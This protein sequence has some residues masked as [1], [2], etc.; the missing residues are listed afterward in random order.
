[1]PNK[2]STK[3]IKR[4]NTNESKHRQKI[5]TY[6][7]PKEKAF[8]LNPVN[9]AAAT[10]YQHPP[11]LSTLLSVYNR[12]TTPQKLLLVLVVLSGIVSVATAVKHTSP[13]IIPG[14]RR[15]CI[16]VKKSTNLA[17]RC[18]IEGKSDHAYFFKKHGQIGVGYIPLSDQ[19]FFDAYTA[20]YNYR[21]VKDV[22][23]VR[24]AQIRLFS[25]A[26]K[27]Y[28]ASRLIPD[29]TLSE[30]FLR[31]GITAEEQNAERSRYTQEIKTKY[32]DKAIVQYAVAMTLIEDMHHANIGF[33]KDG[34][35]IVDS[36]FMPVSIRVY[37]EIAA[38]LNHQIFPF[39]LTLNNVQSMKE[40]YEAMLD[41]K[42]PIGE[43]GLTISEENFKTVLN[44]YIY[45]CRFI[46]ERMATTLDKDELNPAIV[47]VWAGAMEYW[48]ARIENK[49]MRPKP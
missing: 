27:I 25:E 39:H 38:Y 28:T 43:G 17:E 24:H 5:G 32:G 10:A 45:A 13:K 42:M 33:D 29:F 35:V 6:T 23:G 11:T 4:G 9:F 15:D 48:S 31:L 7:Q 36:D 40:M 21:V 37:F 41:K 46:L 44:A 34:V 30:N 19:V 47:G 3:H 26:D 12:L 18:H 16:A 8:S 14:T 1:M 49:P 20:E 2:K 22:I